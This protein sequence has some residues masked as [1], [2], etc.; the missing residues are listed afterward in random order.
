M[1]LPNPASF[2]NEQVQ[3]HRL[4]TQPELR[5]LQ[6]YLRENPGERDAPMQMLK[7]GTWQEWKPKTAA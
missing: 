4:L 7:D 2:T 3:G 5:F 1:S 6:A